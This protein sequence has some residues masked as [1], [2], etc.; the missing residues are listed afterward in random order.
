MHPEAA[1]PGARAGEEWRFVMTSVEHADAKRFGIERIRSAIAGLGLSPDRFQAVTEHLLSLAESRGAT[2]RERMLAATRARAEARPRRRMPHGLTVALRTAGMV[3]AALMLSTLAMAILSRSS[4]RRTT[5]SVEPEADE[6]HVR[7]ALGPMAFTSRATAFRGGV[8]DCWY[9]GGFVDLREA[10]LDPA[11]ALLKVRA[12]FGGGQIVVPETWR[13]TARVRGIGGLGDTRPK[14]EL[15]ADAPHLTIEGLA[16]FG[17]FAVQSELP[18]EEI[19][20]LEKAV[21]RM[22]DPAPIAAEAVPAV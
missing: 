10:T 15:P 7:T 21:A 14:I 9:G 3:W 18:A 12:V 22:S 1:V 2:L 4:A 17:G 13:V 16:L 8:I 6:I 5:A 20:E 19:A 11:G